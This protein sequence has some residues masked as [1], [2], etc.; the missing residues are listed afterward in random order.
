MCDAYKQQTPVSDLFIFETFIHEAIDNLDLET[1]TGP[2]VTTAKRTNS[3]RSSRIRFRRRCRYM[4]DR[5][6]LNWQSIVYT[7]SWQSF[8][9]VVTMEAPIYFKK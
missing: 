1:K 3:F 8:V 2:H 6:P 5:L 4:Y 9:F 7:Y